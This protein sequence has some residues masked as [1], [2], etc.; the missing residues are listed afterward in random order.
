MRACVL[1]NPPTSS[2]QIYSCIQYTRIYVDRYIC[3]HVSR[4]GSGQRTYVHVRWRNLPKHLKHIFHSQVGWSA[5]LGARGMRTSVQICRYSVIFSSRRDLRLRFGICVYYLWC[6]HGL[7]RGKSW[8][9][10][11][12]RLAPQI[13]NAFC[14]EIVHMNRRD[15]N[16]IFIITIITNIRRFWVPFLKLC[17]IA[18]H[19]WGPFVFSLGLCRFKKHRL[20]M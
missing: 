13:T 17:S 9:N 20:R 4:P 18:H 6:V 19:T 5:F 3:A 2:S 1:T 8:S 12:S 14:W 11:G 7:S 15:L 16:S 10:Q